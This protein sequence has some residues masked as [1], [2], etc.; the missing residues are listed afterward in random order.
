MTKSRAEV[1]WRRAI[2]VGAALVLTACSGSSSSSSQPLSA[3]AFGAKY[4]FADNQASGWTQT[5]D[6]TDPFPFGVYTDANLDQRIDGGNK[7]YLDRG[8]RVAMYQDLVGPNGS[9]CTVV[10][11][12]FVTGANATTMFTY[13]KDNKGAATAIPQHDVTVAIGESLITGI[14]V[15]AHDQASYFELQLD[16]YSDQTAAAQAGAQLLGV[17]EGKT[18]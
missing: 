15:F 13:Q 18:K 11:M 2:F 5:T 17:L 12:D 16:G 3:D 8:M 10:A 9:L 6:P 1:V 7:L 14:T 4:K